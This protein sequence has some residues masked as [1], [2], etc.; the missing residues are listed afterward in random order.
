MTIKDTIRKR[1][2]E[3][4]K[5]LGSMENKKVFNRILLLL[6]MWWQDT[7]RQL[8]RTSSL[9]DAQGD[10][11]E[12]EAQRFI[13][14]K[15]FAESESPVLCLARHFAEWQKQKD[16]EALDNNALL[17][18]ARMEGIEIG[19][20]EMKQQM[21]KN[22]LAQCN[23]LTKEQYE[24]ETGFIDSH[25]AKHNCMP[26]FLDAIE[27]GMRLQKDK[28]MKDAIDGK[29][30]ETQARSKLK[31]VTTGNISRLDYKVGDKIKA[32]VIKKD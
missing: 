26:T 11:L 30:Y 31:A 27:Y 12:E 10:D 25:I 16:A 24:L 4:Q 20:A 23:S 32:I 21:E 5:I 15:E 14:T 13:Q 9:K 29:I 3:L 18:I 6:K 22:R 1:D 2:A 8:L 28:M 19:K 17:Y 7:Q